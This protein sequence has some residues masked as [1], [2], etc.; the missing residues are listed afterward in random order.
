ME[1]IK[2][3]MSIS[4]LYMELP[5]PRQEIRHVRRWLRQGA[6]GVDVKKG[7]EQMRACA[8]ARALAHRAPQKRGRYLVWGAGPGAK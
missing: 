5:H 3:N 4:H 8:H 1:D 7:E 2:R 6:D